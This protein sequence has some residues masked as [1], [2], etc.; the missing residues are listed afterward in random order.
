M[1][2][3]IEFGIIALA[4]AANDA[5]ACGSPASEKSS[6][7]PAQKK[8]D[9]QLLYALYQKRGEA[10]KKGAPTE[11]IKLRTD[12]QGR[13]YVDI[14]ATVSSKVTARI[15]KLGGKVVSTDERYRS[16]IAYL[17]LEALEDLASLKVVESIAPVGE[18]I[19]H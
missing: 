2:L 3:G 1:I 12:S 16:V 7:T 17:P 10:E 18:A 9:S 5:Q 11:P 19:T 4:Y 15:E 14:R 6:R 13:A 8:I